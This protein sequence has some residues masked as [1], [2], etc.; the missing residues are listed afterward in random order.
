[1]ETSRVEIDRI[2]SP[3]LGANPGVGGILDSGIGG[4]LHPEVSSDILPY[5]MGPFSSKPPHPVLKKF[6][7]EMEGCSPGGS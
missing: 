4:L 3:E 2:L 1:M 6:P 5:A 7:S